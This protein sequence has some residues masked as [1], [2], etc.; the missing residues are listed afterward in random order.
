MSGVAAIVNPLYKREALLWTCTRAKQLGVEMRNL[1]TSNY[2]T[3]VDQGCVTGVIRPATKL[4]STIHQRTVTVYG[5]T[6]YFQGDKTLATVSSLSPVYNPIDATKNSKADPGAYNALA[7]AG[8]GFKY[9]WVY[10]LQDPVGEQQRP[11]ITE[12]EFS[13]SNSRNRYVYDRLEPDPSSNLAVVLH[14]KSNTR[15]I[16]FQGYSDPTL[17]Y[18]WS[19]GKRENPIDTTNNAQTGTP[20]ATSIVSMDDGTIEVYLY[21][22]DNQMDLYR[23]VYTGTNSSGLWGAPQKVQ[24]AQRASA[25]SGLTVIPDIDLGVN[26]IFYIRSTDTEY[27]DVQDPFKARLSNDADLESEDYIAKLKEQ[28][29]AGGSVERQDGMRYF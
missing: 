3:Y 7:A 29:E 10:F 21:Y 17:Y 25:S 12:Y 23:V 8:D 19:D 27:T 26:H 14:S 24:N 5:I 20:L 18:A 6:T 22:V 11:R 2:S 1:D 13:L 16:M 15:M 4:A 28:S 9:D